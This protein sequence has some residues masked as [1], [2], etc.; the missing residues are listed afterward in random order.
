MQP[1]PSCIVPKTFSAF[2]AHARGASPAVPQSFGQVPAAFPSSEADEKLFVTDGVISVRRA[3]LLFMSGFA[4]AF[5]GR[6]VLRSLFHESGE[7]AASRSMPHNESQTYLF[8]QKPLSSL[9]QLALEE[10]RLLKTLATYAAASAGGYVSSSLLQGLQETW[11]R[12]EETKIRADLLSRMGKTFQ[13]SIRIKQ[14]GDEALK[15]RARDDIRRMLQR[16]N[17][18]DVEVF[19]DERAL[20]EPEEIHRRYFYEPTHRTVRFGQ[21]L[22]ADDPQE[23]HKPP[24]I[25][26]LDVLF[27]GA[28]LM[29][30]LVV[31]GIGRAFK[32]FRV[33]L[34]RHESQV[35]DGAAKVTATMTKSIGL[36]DLEALLVLGQKLNNKMLVLGYGLMVGLAGAG[37]LLIDGLREIEVT[38]VNASTEYRYQKHNWTA[39]DPTFHRIAEEEAVASD[40][41]RLEQDL[42]YLRL[43]PEQLKSRIDAILTNIGRNSAPKYFPMTPPVGLVVARS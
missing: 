5:A 31:Q 11:V 19:L 13:Q 20:V 2:S 23:Y 4:L 42:A 1:S 35:A 15:E 14:D 33:V 43:R 32:S 28:G 22:T 8:F 27:A 26:G 9:F 39:L 16:Y 6:K 25:R 41:K 12:R 38:R 21:Y 10:P 34:G 17:V 36:Y 7:R 40:L 3:A 18:A 37:K 30:G 24:L 29:A